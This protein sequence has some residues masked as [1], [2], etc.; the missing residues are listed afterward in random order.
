MSDVPKEK[1]KLLFNDLLNGFCSTIYKNKTINI[2][3]LTHFDVADFDLKYSVHFEEAKRQGAQ[4]VKEREQYLITE[5]S[6]SAEKDKDIQNN[7]LFV[8]GLRDTKAKLFRQSEIDKINN[9]IAE[10]EKKIRDLENEKNQLLQYT[11]ESFANKKITEYQIFRSLFYNNQPFFTEEEY[12]QLT[13]NDLA[14]ISV[15]YNEKFAHFNERTFRRIAISNFFLNSF[16]LCKDNPF[17]FYGKAVMQLTL[18]Q[19]EVF[20]HAVYFKHLLNHAPSKPPQ[21]IMEDPDKLVD[22]S[23]ANNSVKKV[24]ESGKKP[25]DLVGLS[26][27]DRETLGLK[28]PNNNIHNKLIDAAKAKGSALTAM[29]IMKLQGVSYQ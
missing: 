20:S 15:I 25:E 11:A 10:S 7:Q 2:K 24:L 18:F 13:D 9:S 26:G 5:G 28:T 27:K 12:E 23:N 4:T 21:E 6:W 1:L 8:S 22:W 3:H 17:T 19:I 14:E 29:E 16:Y